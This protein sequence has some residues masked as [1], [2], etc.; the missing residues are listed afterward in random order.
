MNVLAGQI[1]FKEYAT[2]KEFLWNSL[3]ISMV[4]KK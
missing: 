2:F 3:G 4:Q 1:D